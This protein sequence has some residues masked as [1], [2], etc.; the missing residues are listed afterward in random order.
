MSKESPTLEFWYDFGSTYSFLSALRIEDLAGRAGVTIAWKPFLLGPIFEA[1]GWTTSPFNLYPAKGRYM[2]RD[3]ERICDARGHPFRLPTPFPQNSLLAARLALAG[4][5]EGWAPPFT[6][7]VYMA[8]FC[9]GASISEKTDLA[10]ILQGL[11]LDPVQVFAVIEE[12]PLKDR[13]RRQTT[14]AQQ[15]GIFGAP[16]FLTPN[17]E[18]FWGDDRLEQAIAWVYRR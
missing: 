6:R 9:H 7:A 16:T 5:E 15:R 1:Q 4:V 3:M 18:P 13:L 11:H 14:E 10:P 2:V 17:G 12:K 8:E